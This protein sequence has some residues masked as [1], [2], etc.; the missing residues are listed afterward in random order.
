VHVEIWLEE[1]AL[2]GVISSITEMYDVRL[3]VASGYASISFL[4]EAAQHLKYVDKPTFIY[5]LGD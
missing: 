1:D 4:H 3:M 5:H 2:A